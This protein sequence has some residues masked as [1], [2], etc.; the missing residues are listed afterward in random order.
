MTVCDCAADV[1]ADEPPALPLVTLPPLP[2]ELCEGDAPPPDEVVAAEDWP[3]PPPAEL[4]AVGLDVVP[5]LLDVV[6]AEEEAG[7]DVGATE[8]VGSA[9]EVGATEVVGAAED[10]I[11]YPARA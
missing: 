10:D 9:D 6:C 2:P 3:P 8:E 4:D 7:A 11:V 1:V 5:P